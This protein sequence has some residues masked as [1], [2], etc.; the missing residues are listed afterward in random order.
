MSHFILSFRISFALHIL[1]QS[2]MFYIVNNMAFYSTNSSCASS[3]TGLP[4][5]LY[6]FSLEAKK[7]RMKNKLYTVLSGALKGIPS[8]C[9]QT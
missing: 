3:F 4:L 5:P 7:L 9:N 2:N 1:N 6:N 8:A